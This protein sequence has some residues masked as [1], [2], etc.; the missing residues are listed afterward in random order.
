MRT[1]R[2]SGLAL[3]LLLLAPAAGRADIFTEVGDAGQTVGTAQTTVG[4][5]FL[6]EIRGTI[7]SPGPTGDV[8]L[9]VIFISNPS[10]FSATTVGTPGTLANTQLFL[11]DVNGRGVYANDDASAAT[12][13]STLPAGSP[14][15]PTAPGIY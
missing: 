1:H 5:G 8:D 10:G 9:F 13:R 4:A 11:F 3:A 14:L 15:G 2:V 6:D 12:G 7:G